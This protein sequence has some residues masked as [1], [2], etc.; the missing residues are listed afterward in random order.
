MKNRQ[1]WNKKALN[2]IRGK[3]YILNDQL[4]ELVEKYQ[5]QRLGQIICNYICPDYRDKNPSF[6]TQFWLATDIFP[7]DID[8]FFEEPW[9]T[10]KRL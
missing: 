7:K 3:Y 1:E 8:F 5:Y 4:D 6:Q 2:K 9:D 10:Y